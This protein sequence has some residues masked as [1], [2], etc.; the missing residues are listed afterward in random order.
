[1]R[2][3]T[4]FEEFY[5]E[6]IKYKE[7]H[8]VCSFPENYSKDGSNYGRIQSNIRD[9]GRYVNAEQRRMLNEI[10]FVWKVRVVTSFDEV[11]LLLEKFK[12]EHGHC[13]VPAKYVT[14]DGINLGG[15]V[16]NIRSGN[17]KT[18]NEQK[19]RLDDIGFVWEIRSV[20][21]QNED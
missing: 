12:A 9:G 13:L 3:L 18:S 21:S 7:E 4:S 5:N 15:I 2:K 17:R 20:K 1:M 19:K 8:G 16:R 14:E 10:G 11:I 6:L